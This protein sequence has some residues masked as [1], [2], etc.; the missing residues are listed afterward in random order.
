MQHHPDSEAK[1]DQEKN[2]RWEARRQKEPLVLAHQRIKAL[3]TENE[4]LQLEVIR[5]KT[6][7]NETFGK[8]GR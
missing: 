8:F 4:R 3:E 1:R 5:L 6:L 7:L 2:L